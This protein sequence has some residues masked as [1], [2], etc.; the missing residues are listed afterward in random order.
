VQLKLCLPGFFSGSATPMQAAPCNDVRPLVVFVTLIVCTAA[1][2]VGIWFLSGPTHIYRSAARH[3]SSTRTP[4]RHRVNFPGA[5]EE[6]SS[7]SSVYLQF[8]A[9]RQE[10]RMFAPFHS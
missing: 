10:F 2:F 5:R 8:F 7:F 3:C 9:F 1:E 4:P 6:G